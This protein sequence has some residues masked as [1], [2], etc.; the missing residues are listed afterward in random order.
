[1][2]TAGANVTGVKPPP[3]PPPTMPVEQLI[4]SMKP[5]KELSTEGSYSSGGYGQSS[6]M[7]SASSTTPQ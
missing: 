3:P 1:M 2:T 4:Q 5:E 7:S 6:S